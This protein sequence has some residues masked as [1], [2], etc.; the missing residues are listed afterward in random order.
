MLAQ[1]GSFVIFK[2]IQ[3]R[4]AKKPFIFV[5]FQGGG[6]GPDPLSL[7]IRAC[8]GPMK[9]N[10]LS[11]FIVK[12]FQFKHLLWVLKRTGMLGVLFQF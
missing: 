4:F 12:Y 10:V 3:T 11:A 5:I 7:L 2:G 6:G 8:R 1:L 9:Q